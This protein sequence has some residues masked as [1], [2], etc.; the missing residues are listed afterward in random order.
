[1]LKVLKVLKA[2]DAM[3]RIRMQQYD[4]TRCRRDNVGGARHLPV[5][6]SSWKKSMF[7]LKMSMEVKVMS[8]MSV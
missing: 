1:M 5:R 6:A 3:K 7:W 8:G 4:V 2:G